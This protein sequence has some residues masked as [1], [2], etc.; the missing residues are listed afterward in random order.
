MKVSV[1]YGALNR[2]EQ[3]VNAGTGFGLHGSGQVAFDKN[4]NFDVQMTGGREI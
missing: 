1:I 3:A 2:L 4:G